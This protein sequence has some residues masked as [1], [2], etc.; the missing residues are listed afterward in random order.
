[1]DTYVS[2]CVC[3]IYYGTITNR[4]AS[5]PRP[6]RSGNHITEGRK[7]WSYLCRSIA[8]H[9]QSQSH[10]YLIYS[11]AWLIVRSSIV[12][13]GA[14]WFVW[15][16]ARELGRHLL[17]LDG[18]VL[19]Y[20]LDQRQHYVEQQVYLL[21]LSYVQVRHEALRYLPHLTYFL[22]TPLFYFFILQICTWLFFLYCFAEGKEW[23][24]RLLE[25]FVDQMALE[26]I[27]YI[28]RYILIRYPPY[29]IARDEDGIRMRQKCF[30][31]IVTFEVAVWFYPCVQVL[32]TLIRLHRYLMLLGVNVRIALL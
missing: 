7:V 6:G 27:Y 12:V 4:D 13:T 26:S 10:F 24:A 20:G 22:F 9:P 21:L 11:Y 16:S 3:S 31:G 32:S 28:L 2:S 1:M 30:Q 29:G 5:V 17:Q 8:I 18:L 23:D 14:I 15:L 25:I 19:V